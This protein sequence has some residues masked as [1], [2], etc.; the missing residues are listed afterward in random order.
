MIEET[1]HCEL[2]GTMPVYEKSQSQKFRV[3]AFQHKGGW[4]AM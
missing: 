3:I 1:G 4:S 2:Q